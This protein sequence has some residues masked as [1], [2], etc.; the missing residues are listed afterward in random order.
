METVGLMP[1]DTGQPGGKR[2]GQHM[3][4]Y[5]TKEGRYEQAFHTMPEEYKLPFTSLEGDW[6]QSLPAGT[7]GSKVKSGKSEMPVGANVAAGIARGGKS[8]EKTK[9][10][11]PDCGINVW[12]KPELN[13][14]CG[15]CD[16]KLEATS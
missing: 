2:T 5:L 9:Y 10:N 13:L 4:H 14:S 16:R 8:R 12:G 1:S 7:G 15:D 11:C 6:M 3:T